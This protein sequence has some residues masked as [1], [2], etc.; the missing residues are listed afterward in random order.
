MRLID[1]KKAPKTEWRRSKMGYEFDLLSDFWQLDG[2]ITVNLGRMRKLDVVTQ[3]GFRMALGRYAE[4]LAGP[5][6]NAILGCFNAYC[7]ATGE[8]NVNVVGLSNWRATLTNEAEARLGALKSFL[9]AW[10]EW[11]FPGVGKDVVDY[12]D[13]LRLKGIVKGKAV[14][15]A[16]PFSGPL[17]T[18]EQ[19]ALLDWVAAAFTEEKITLSQYALFLALSFTGRRMVQIR[20]LR[21]CDLLARDDAKGREYVLK[22]PRVKQPGV[23][24]REAFRSIPIV[25]DLYQVLRTQSISSQQ[26]VEAQL[27]TTISEHLKNQIPIFL[28]IERVGKLNSIEQLMQELE[29]RPDYLHMSEK[30]SFEELGEVAKKNTARSERTGD[31]I[32]FTSRRFRYTKGTNLARRGIFGVSLAEALDHSSTQNIH[33]YVENTPETADIIDETMAPILAPLA[34]AFAGVLIDSERDALRAND[35]HSRIK[36]NKQN[37]VGSC[38]TYAFCASGYR[39]CY[40]CIKF[41]PWRDAPH[42][43]VRDEILMERRRQAELGISPNVIQSTD[44]LLL[45]VEQVILLCKAAKEVSINGRSNFL[46]TTL[47]IEC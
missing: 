26:L 25:N 9:I 36:N 30:S 45:S 11:G 39:T 47:N 28:E 6:T 32:N 42:E 14:T 23:G 40:T 38:G 31:F 8:S 44:R 10:Y 29:A 18:Q 7:D 1:S 16:C 19:G 13:S 15:G 12:L 27:G 34:Q 17:S 41:Q 33:V 46:Q 37:N 24:F 5:T 3:K 20:S 2:S 4:E 43:E 22:V 21:A 35:P